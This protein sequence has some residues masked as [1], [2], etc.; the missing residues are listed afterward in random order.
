MLVLHLRA[1]TYCA[2]NA[3]IAFLLQKKNAIDLSAVNVMF[4]NLK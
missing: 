4:A 1:R 3:F 2:F